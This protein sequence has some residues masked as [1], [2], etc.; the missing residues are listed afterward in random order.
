VRGEAV[1]RRFAGTALLA[2]ALSSGAAFAAGPPAPFTPWSFVVSGDSRDCGDLIMPKIARAV[3]AEPDGVSFY[4]HLGDFRRIYDI[5]CDVLKRSHPDF[6]CKGRD[7]AGVGA[8][9]MAAYEE[10]AFRDFVEFQMKPF[11]SIPVLL[12]IGNH[13]LYGG[14]TRAEFDEAFRPW[15][16]QKRLHL[17]RLADA[18][19]G[20]SEAGRTTY[21]FVDRGVDFLYLDNADET[22]FSAAQLLWLAKVLAQDA[23]N[24]AVKTIVVGMHEALPFSTA[25]IHAMDASC[26]GI[27]SGQQAYDLIYRAQNLSGPPEKRKKVY[28]LASHAHAYLENVYDTPEH[29]GQVLPG[30][31]VGT[32]GAIQSSEQI[33]YG[34][35]RFDVAADGTLTPRFREVTRASPPL[36]EGPGG[37]SL[38][39][40]CFTQN[41]RVQVDDS[42]KGDCACGA[43]R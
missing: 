43:A 23:K 34:Y 42:V 10:G 35:V 4:W 7:M 29:R 32:A 19:K 20:I 1:R 28:V 8:G 21:H 22:S 36:A 5:D 27:C 11:G 9:E 30:W 25:R 12:G 16:S 18:A 2:A 40:F 37:E 41:I 26:Q 14:R 6:D 33:A 38:T 17:Q 39:D 3:A 15:L 31:I 13:E 24:D